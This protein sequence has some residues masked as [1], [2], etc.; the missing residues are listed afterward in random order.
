MVGPGWAMVGDAAGFIDPIFSTGLYLGMK[1]AFEL[2]KAI[3]RGTPAAMAKYE[4]GR[5]RE[6]KMWQ[7]V[8]NS[9]YDGKL[10]NLYRAGQRHKHNMLGRR[11]EKRVR[12]RLIRIFTGQAVDNFYAMR[13][14]EHLTALGTLLRDPSDL[15]V[16]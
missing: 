5:H 12:K 16:Q 8:I 2:F 10:F 4:A 7:H 13:I 14:F 15:V 9:W 1:G 3:D 6:L 11:I